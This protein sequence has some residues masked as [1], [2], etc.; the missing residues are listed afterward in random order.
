MEAAAHLLGQAE[1]EHRIV[2]LVSDFRARQWDDPGPIKKLLLDWNAAGIKVRM[3]DCVE[4]A[5]PNLAIRQLSPGPG[6]RAAGVPLFME[7]TV[8]NFGS[9][10]A[11]DVPV[12]VEADGVAQPAVSIAQIPPRR[13]VKERFPVRFPTAGQ[14]R[15]TARLEADAV[16]A[17]N[18]RYV[19]VDFAASVPVLLIDGDPEAKDARY[20]SAVFAPGGPTKTGI[21]PRIET[22][23]YLSLQPLESFQ[24]IYLL[25]VERLEKSAV[26]ALEQ[27]VASGGGVGFFLGERSQGQFIND[28][29][30]RGG[31]GLFPLPVVRPTELLVDY[32]QKA[33]DMAVTDHPIFHVLAGE[34]NSFLPL[35]IVRRYFSVPKDWR[36]E[37]DP[38]VTVIARLRNGAPLAAE[39]RFGRGRVVAFL[40]TAAPEWNNWAR[41]N[42]SFVV[43]MLEMQ[44]YLTAR[45]AA[46]VPRLVGAPLEVK[47]D[48]GQYEPQ[49]RFATPKEDTSPTATVEAAPTPDGQLVASL[50]NTD[51]SGIY[52]ARL[53][54]KDGKEEIRTW[55]VNVDTEEGDLRT[56]T[57]PELAAR[58]E[59]VKHE[60]QLASAYQYSSEQEAGYNLATALLCLLVL[61]LVGEQILAYSASYHPPSLQRGHAG[62]GGR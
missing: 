47:L 34:R 52:Q 44:A 23:R 32:L 20:L 27:Y 18:F 7:V 36:A 48:P 49:V 38:G 28:A 26:S 3:I 1:G 12:L 29:L 5:R 16:L 21:S 2:Y 25:N 19:V 59:G 57:Y 6:T 50:A 30:Y 8:E 17:D 55:A 24:A 62:G 51:I 58:L 33:P 40:T 60:F 45:P 4:A 14:H 15:I 9:V 39:R 46:E 37:S 35:V 54:R 41:E 22:P 11:K 10:P 31:Q 42:P 61:L 53:A 56:L 43:S 13:A